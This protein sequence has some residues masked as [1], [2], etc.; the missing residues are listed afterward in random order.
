MGPGQAFAKGQW[1]FKKST[2][3]IWKFVAAMSGMQ[4]CVQ[5]KHKLLDL[6]FFELDVLTHD[7]VVLLKNDFFRRRARILLGDI[8]EACAGRRQQFDLL[9]NRLS[10]GEIAPE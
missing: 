9:G 4:R 7:G 2:F 10:H 6:G 1:A 8:E 3:S 5:P